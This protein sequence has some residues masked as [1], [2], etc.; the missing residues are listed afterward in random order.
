MPRDPVITA[1]YAACGRGEIETERCAR[2]SLFRC[3]LQR[4]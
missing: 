3:D 2:F 1:G 4:P